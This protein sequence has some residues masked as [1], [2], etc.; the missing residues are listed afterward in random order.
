MWHMR[1]R[2][3]QNVLMVW[4]LMSISQMAPYLHFTARNRIRLLY[5]INSS[6]YLA[7]NWTL[8]STLKWA[9]HKKPFPKVHLDDLISSW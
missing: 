8:L 9:I 4:R 6:K 5:T 1:A 2:A 3:I 7:I